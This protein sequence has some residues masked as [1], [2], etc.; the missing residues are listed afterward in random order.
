MTDKELLAMCQAAFEAIPVAS[1]ARKVLRKLDRIPEA[2]AGNGSHIL[3][4]TMAK[5]IDDHLQ[6]GL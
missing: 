3:S 5:M 4:A 6:G 1:Q 2:Y